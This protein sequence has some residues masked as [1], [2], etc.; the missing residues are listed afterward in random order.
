MSQIGDPRKSFKFDKDNFLLKFS[1]VFNNEEVK[2]EFKK[3]L[4]TE[5]N[6]EPFDC[7]LEIE[8][9]KEI[10]DEKE[11][12]IK[13]SSILTTYFLNGSENQVNISHEKRKMLEK[14]Y[15]EEIENNETWTFEKLPKDVFQDVERVLKQELQHDS[16][17]R[18][19]RT[20][21]C[22]TMIQKHVL[23]PSIVI[24]KLTSSY[25][26]TI[27]SFRTPYIEDIDF[28]FA[29]DIS[30]DDF[31]WE[32]LGSKVDNNINTFISSVNHL[33]GIGNSIKTSASKFECVFP[34]SIEQIIMANYT[35]KGVCSD[36]SI[37]N[38]KFSDFKT[39]K[40]IKEHFKDNPEKC[41][42]YIPRAQCSVV[43]SIQL[44]KPLNMRLLSTV[45]SYHYDKENKI[46]LNVSKP[47]LKEENWLKQIKTKVGID[48]EGTE[49]MKKVY[50]MFS[51][52]GTYMKEIDEN[53]TLFSQFNMANI[54]GWANNDKLLKYVLQDRG[55]KMRKSIIAAVENMKDS[56]N[57]SNIDELAKTDQFCRILSELDF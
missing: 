25:D 24:A 28:E 39:Y 16:F 30:K 2:K 31:S 19:I 5:F 46:F 50:H 12:I 43:F 22:G 18:F 36:L 10:K 42:K 4:K 1:S 53:K 20:P 23:N 55:V 37:K 32:L 54:A 52:S 45:C 11:Q 15:K 34:F 26:F 9:L 41:E 17:K 47:F 48:S 40:E 57:I 33:P 3:F 8:K 27:E 38:S 51:F 6:S 13:V 7:L 14:I 44:P 21:I 29:C 49:K 56:E 35:E